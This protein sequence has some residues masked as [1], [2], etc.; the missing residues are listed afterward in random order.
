MPKPLHVVYSV[1]PLL[2]HSASCTAASVRTARSTGLVLFTRFWSA[3]TAT[4]IDATGHTETHA[5]SRPL[6]THQQLN[7]GLDKTTPHTK[8]LLSV[9]LLPA[10]VHSVNSAALQTSPYKIRDHSQ[11][12]WHKQLIQVSEGP[13]HRQTPQTPQ[14]SCPQI[15]HV[16]S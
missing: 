14:F 10:N 3:T 6:P 2:T 5:S 15:F 8:S 1:Q 12:R 16:L 9:R 13:P 4:A 11:C 7:S